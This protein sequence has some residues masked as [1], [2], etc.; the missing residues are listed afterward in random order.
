NAGT[1]AVN[2]IFG[3]TVGNAATVNVTAG[4]TL[5]GAGTIRGSV[6]V[7]N[8]GIVGAGNSPGTLTV[9]G[10]YTLNNAS[11]SNFELNT[12]G[13]VNGLTNDLIVVGGNLTLDGQVN[14]INAN[15]SGYY[16][17]F[18]YG[19][20]LTDNGTTVTATNGTATILTNISQQVNASVS[21]G[22][23]LVQFWDGADQTG[24]PG[25]S[26]GGAINGG[27]G[28][29]NA[30]NTNWTQAPNFGVNDQWRSQVG[31]FAGAAGT[32]TVVGTQSFQGLQFSTTGYTVTGGALQM[33][34]NPTVNPNASFI[35]VDPGVT[36]TIAS[37]ISGSAANIGLD[38]E[39]NGTLVLS[40]ANT[41]TGTTTINAG[42]LEVQ[43]GAAIVDTGA[44]VIA[45]VAG[46]TLAVTNSETIG[47]LAGGGTTGG[48]V[49][50]ATG[51]VLTTGNA[52]NT[53]FAGNI[54]GAGGL[55]K[56][57][58]GV[59][60]LS[61]TN[62]YGGTTTINAGTLEVQNGAAILDTGAVTIANVAGA[63]LLVT[64]SETIG[65]LAGTGPNGTVTIANAQTLTTGGNNAST[66]FGGTIGGAGGLTKQG[67]GVFTL[68]GSNTY[69]GTTTI[70][71]GTLEVQNGAAILDTGAVTIA[72]V[73]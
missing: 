39:G 17:L 12:P 34:G 56:Q 51:Q 54:S 33:T 9:A 29:W 4:G 24:N 37:T 5:Q 46:A 65:S 26:G 49:T 70:N 72:N 1:L 20:T 36:A 23:Q 8:G 32:V 44:V 66:T 57:G 45:N 16:R 69:G 3:D 15:L 27:T 30:T 55:T 7:A 67:T 60:T 21:L 52:S 31:V 22:G 68:S 38:K 42:T 58:T 59:F 19:G 28:T 71:A 63:T 14:L 40:G 13:F 53:T 50:I 62:T 25:N 10:D 11:I 35:I 41:Y 73:A 43:G 64:N 2:G 18:N 48:G 47:S 6:V 61:G